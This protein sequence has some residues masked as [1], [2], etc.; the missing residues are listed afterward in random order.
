MTTLFLAH[1]QVK[2]LP[3]CDV[4]IA[5]SMSVVR[6]FGLMIPASNRRLGRTFSGDLLGFGDWASSTSRSRT[7]QAERTPARNHDLLILV[8]TIAP[9][10]AFA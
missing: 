4:M 10:L 5:A 1:N 7:T 3:I 8:L 9:L 2:H 6:N